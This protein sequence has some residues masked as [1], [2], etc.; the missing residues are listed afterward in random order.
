[1]DDSTVITPDVETTPTNEPVDATVVIDATVDANPIDAT[2]VIQSAIQNAPAQSWL[3]AANELPKGWRLNGHGLYRLTEQI[4]PVSG[5]VTQIACRIA[6]PVWVAGQ[7]RTAES[8]DWSRVVK[9]ID[10]DHRL[11]EQTLSNARLHEPSNTLC[12]EL[13]K[14]GLKICHRKEG[15]LLEYLTNCEPP[16]RYRLAA[17]TGWI[18][19]ADGALLYIRPGAIQTNA[20]DAETYCY[21]GRFAPAKSAGTLEEWRDNVALPCAN[22]PYLVFA[23]CAA[24]A[25]P[26]LK[27]AGI[28]SGGFTLGGLTTAGKTTALQVAASVWGHGGDP[29]AYGEAAYCRS[30]SM[31]P[32]AL[33][34]VA[35]S[36]NDSLLCLDEL[37]K[38]DRST[39]SR[40]VY[41]LSGGSGKAR[42]LPDGE[43][44]ALRSWRV[45]I[46]SSGELSSADKIAESGTK[47]K[48]GQLLRLL[49][50]RVPESGIFSHGQDADAADNLKRVCAQFYGTA[51]PAF[52]AGLIDGLD[53]VQIHEK[54]S[55]AVQRHAE[56]LIPVNATA[57][58]KRAIK[59]FALVKIAGLIACNAGVIPFDAPLISSSIRFVLDAWLLDRQG[60]ASDS[61]RALSDLR[62]FLLSNRS[63]MMFTDESATHVPPKLI[64]YV[65][66]RDSLGNEP[67]LI[68]L[69]N[70]GLREA[71][72]GHD[73]RMVLCELDR[74]GLLKKSQGYK[75]RAHIESVGQQI[76][77]Y[78]IR[79]GIFDVGHEPES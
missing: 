46:L 75:Y 28:E 60:D 61:E 72:A 58:T 54:V 53:A 36:H 23:L 65:H 43:M 13:A 1:M 34:S 8:G 63:R 37:G 33:E 50:I 69:S 74:R 52:I 64:G 45:F 2:T 15:V 48:G 16:K 19:R 17:E 76:W 42:G 56:S 73:S 18:D 44:R 26:L 27:Y 79:P 49:D 5:A 7:V 11:H 59:K 68:L 62:G 77:L 31:T 10:R 21:S 66:R 35:A 9:W 29:G 39:Y 71:V 57:E 41:L 4:D 14:G 78:A 51:G 38:A 55:R 47:A 3:E 22:H 70:E 24:F 30:W 12:A 20:I 32:T 40:M 67:D 25:G 6:G